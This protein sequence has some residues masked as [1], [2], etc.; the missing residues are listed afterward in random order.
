MIL[1]AN[2][3]NNEKTNINSNRRNINENTAISP[4][5]CSL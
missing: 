5:Q 4:K 2:S 3:N 1:D